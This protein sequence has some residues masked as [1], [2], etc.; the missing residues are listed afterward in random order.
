MNLAANRRVQCTETQCPNHEMTPK[1]ALLLRS[2]EYKAN[3]IEGHLRKKRRR[4]RA[5]TRAFLF[6]QPSTGY[7]R[8]RPAGAPHTRSPLVGFRSRSRSRERASDRKETAATP[9][10]MESDFSV[11]IP[12]YCSWSGPASELSNHL[13]RCPYEVI[14][15]KHCKDMVFRQRIKQHHR[16]CLRCPVQCTKCPRKM[17]RCLMSSSMTCH[18][19]QLNELGESA[20]SHFVGEGPSNVFNFNTSKSMRVRG[21]AV[22]VAPVNTDCAEWNWLKSGRFGHERGS[23]F[24]GIGSD[25]HCKEVVT[26]LGEMCIFERGEQ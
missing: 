23:V 22:T 11:P 18:L 26:R 2:M 3:S 4:G 12:G 13:K 7:D 15:C 20:S 9:T 8:V 14:R 19:C 17:A 25:A 21:C 6:R 16:E 24:D 1:R 5:R 10:S